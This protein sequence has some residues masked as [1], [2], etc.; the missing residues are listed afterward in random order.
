MTTAEKLFMDKI[1]FNRGFIKNKKKFDDIVCDIYSH[2]TVR[3]KD[4][5]TELKRFGLQFVWNVVTR[6]SF[7]DQELLMDEI[8]SLTRCDIAQAKTLLQKY[9]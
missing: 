9:I 1:E 8:N 5:C 4:E 6:L 2:G 7:T 3:W